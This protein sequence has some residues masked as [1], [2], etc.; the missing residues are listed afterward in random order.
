MLV[1]HISLNN[2][3]PKMSH[4]ILGQKK[5]SPNNFIAKSCL[6]QYYVSPKLFFTQLKFHPNYTY[7]RF[8]SI[9]FIHLTYIAQEIIAQFL[10]ITHKPLR[11]GWAKA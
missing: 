9:F 7:L 11:L 10:I 8:S 6:T 1:E 5:V 3:S 2:V 4:P